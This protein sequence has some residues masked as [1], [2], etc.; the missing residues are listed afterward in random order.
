MGKIDTGGLAEDKTL[1]DEFA[2]QVLAHIS[3]LI[4][5]AMDNHESPTAKDTVRISYEVATAMIAEKRRLEGE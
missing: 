3:P 1:L 5:R 4:L 2:G